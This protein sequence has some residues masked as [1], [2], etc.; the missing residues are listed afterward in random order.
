MAIASMYTPQALRIKVREVPFSLHGNGYHE[1]CIST[2]HGT[3]YG[4]VLVNS[5]PG[6][7]VPVYT[8]DEGLPG[9]GSLDPFGHFIH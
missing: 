8:I 2:D 5:L 7:Q 3:Y 6:P 4:C 9:E 1:I